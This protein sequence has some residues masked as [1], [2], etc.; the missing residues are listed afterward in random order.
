MTI[1]QALTS[2]G[3]AE[4]TFGGVVTTPA[5]FVATRSGM[6]EHFRVRSDDGV[7]VEVAD[8]VSIA[9]PCPV[10]PGDHIEIRGECTRAYADGSP[11]VHWTHR[12]PRQR[13][14]DGFIQLDGR[15][16]A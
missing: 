2:G 13:H 10:K 6:H 3:A 8:N 16:Y 14:P 4:V 7:E 11:L 5:R 12:D 9:R 1:A 15:R